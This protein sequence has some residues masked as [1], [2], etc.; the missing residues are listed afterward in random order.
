MGGNVQHSDNNTPVSDDKKLDR[1]G[2][3]PS[4]PTL[5][6]V[7]DKFAL[8]KAGVE[9]KLELNR[10]V[11]L[12]MY[13]VEGV[14][15]GYPIDFLDNDR[16]AIAVLCRL[17]H[18]QV[19][20]SERVALRKA[21][22]ASLKLWQGIPADS[23]L[24]IENPA[25]IV[26]GSD[27]T[28]PDLSPF[29]VCQKCL[30]CLYG[31]PPLGVGISPQFSYYRN[32]RFVASGV[33]W[34]VNGEILPF[35]PAPGRLPAAVCGQIIV[36]AS[37]AAKSPSEMSSIEQ[38]YVNAISWFRR[39]RLEENAITKFM[40]YWIA[41]E[42]CFPRSFK[43]GQIRSSL[44]IFFGTVGK[45]HECFLRR[46]D[47]A[48]LAALGDNR[49]E[50]LDEYDKMCNLRAEVVHNGATELTLPNTKR[51][52]Y[53]WGTHLLRHQL[54]PKA[55]WTLTEAIREGRAKIESVWRDFVVHLVFS[56]SYSAWR[57]DNFGR[58]FYEDGPRQL[59]LTDTHW[60]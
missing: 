11:D 58:S 12:W 47:R 13:L 43:Q 6:E 52:D 55:L 26:T 18:L 57:K 15:V 14:I 30:D 21:L 27:G 22:S 49:N 51:D 36:D 7:M 35:R 44:A 24:Y 42:S 8:R 9:G 5:Y 45:K 59:L 54:L 53:R 2:T 17:S 32:D 56:D 48:V 23:E 39:G 4:R 1:P 29:R 46:D 20:D 16:K 40:S 28:Q 19:S 10:Q 33:R 60:D 3:G 38:C 31:T 50:F 25:F 41:L 34:K 37:V